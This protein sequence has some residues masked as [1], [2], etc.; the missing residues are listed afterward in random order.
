MQLVIHILFW[1]RT[2]V[3]KLNATNLG[4]VESALHFPAV[5]AE[6]YLVSLTPFLVSDPPFSIFLT[7]SY[8]LDLSNS[9]TTAYPRTKSLTSKRTRLV[10]LPPPS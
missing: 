4:S 8:T 1:K 10:M 3:Q 9:H 6:G 7:Y 5:M 2:S